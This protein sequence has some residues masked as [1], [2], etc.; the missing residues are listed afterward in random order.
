M[1]FG[2]ALLSFV[3]YQVIFNLGA[4][5]SYS[6]AEDEFIVLAAILFTMVWQMFRFM[7]NTLA[8]GIG[9]RKLYDPSTELLQ[10]PLA[11]LPYFFQTASFFSQTQ[12]TTSFPKM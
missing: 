2:N 3:A 11:R 9:T 5:C 1:T 8:S 4:T 12:E 10:L 7:R 6:N